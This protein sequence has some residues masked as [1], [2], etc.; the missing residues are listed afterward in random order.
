MNFIGWIYRKK[1]RVFVYG[2]L[3][4]GH[5]NHRLLEHEKFLKKDT[6]SGFSMHSLGAFPAIRPNPA[7]KVIGEIYEISEATLRN[8]DYLEGV[9]HGF[10]KRL[11]ITTDSGLSAFVYALDNAGQYPVV[12]T[13]DWED[14]KR[15]DFESVAFDDSVGPDEE[16][17]FADQT[18]EF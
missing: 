12:E 9:D 4:Q 15:M 6:L 8:L 1:I 14:S 7:Y 16:E 18:I 2:T 11:S 17:D 5:G 10:Y 3:R 13:G